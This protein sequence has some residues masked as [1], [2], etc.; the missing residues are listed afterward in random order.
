MMGGTSI[1]L[2]LYIRKQA[3]KGQRRKTT[4]SLLSLVPIDLN[5]SYTASMPQRKF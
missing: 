5:T 4:L 2:I 3:G 1:I